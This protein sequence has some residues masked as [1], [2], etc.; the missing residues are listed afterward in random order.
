MI[1]AVLDA[2]VL[3]SAFLAAHGPPGQVLDAWRER[4]LTVAISEAIL[5]EVGRVLRYPK[6]QKRHGWSERR[7]RLF[8][9]RLR[10]LSLLTPDRLR[11]RAIADD[12][13][14]NAYLACAL[15]AGAAYVVTG[16]EHLLR[17]KE[18]QGIRILSPRDFL[19]VLRRE[20]QTPAAPKS[21]PPNDP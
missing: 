11:V 12:P 5:A 4:R 13:D 2:N 10:R 15:E 8:L 17:L 7:T 21:T 3:V 9:R 19:E 6:I 18:Y 1:R 14:D 20:G 16:D